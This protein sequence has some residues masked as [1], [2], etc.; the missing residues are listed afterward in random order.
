M[1]STFIYT[2]YNSNLNT[3]IRKE[4]FEMTLK[5]IL[6]GIFLL[7]G[8]IL[9]GL[10]IFLNVQDMTEKKLDPA[11]KHLEDVADDLRS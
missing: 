5:A 4:E 2:S 6:G 11:I 3:Y 8:S 1:A 7:G 9:Q 10:G